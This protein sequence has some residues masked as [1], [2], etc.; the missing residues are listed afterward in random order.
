VLIS[1]LVPMLAA[2]LVST[3]T[4]VPAYA[5]ASDTVRRIVIEARQFEYSPSVIRVNRGEKIELVLRSMDVTHGLSLEE[6]GI[7]LE[8]VPG[9]EAH[10][11]FYAD[12]QG[13]F[14]FR[15]NQVCGNLHPFMTGGLIVEPNRPFWMVFALAVLGSVAFGAYARVRRGPGLVEA[16]GGNVNRLSLSGGI[17]IPT[18]SSGSR[19]IRFDV[20]GIRWIRWLLNRR[21]FQFVLLLP[22]LMVLVLILVAGFAGSPVG[23]HNLAIVLVWSIWWALLVLVLIPIGGRAWCVACPIPAP[24]EWLQR[25]ALVRKKEGKPFTIGLSWPRWLRN[26]WPQN[27]AFLCVAALSTIVLT[28]PAMTAWV[29]VAFVGT[30]TAMA[31]LFRGRIF[32]RYICPLS[33]FIGLYTLAAPLSLRVRSKEVCRAHREKSC[34]TG[35]ECGYGCPWGEY[36]GT[37]DRGVDCGLCME[38]VKT[39]SE[40]NIAVGFQAPGHDLVRTKA[41]KDEAFRAAI[42]ISVAFVYTV[43]MLG[44]WGWFKTAAGNPVSVP[45]LLYLV[46]LAGTSL[47]VV[48]GALLGV[49]YLFRKLS[50]VTHVST[51]R[52][53]AN[54][55]YSL[56]PLGLLVWMIFAATA[57]SAGGSHL[58]TV[59]S[60]PLGRGWDLFGTAHVK[61]PPLFPQLLPY[62]QGTGL[63]VGLIGSLAVF[64]H[65]MG[66]DILRWNPRLWLG[67]GAV[68]VTLFGITSLFIWLMMG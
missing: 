38:C 51:T 21:S 11:E 29:L 64:R 9:E 4:A 53:W 50:G 22:A 15:C 12:R 36:P 3:G 55:C 6:Y 58:P 62:L 46:F 37:M 23:D 63:L 20:T 44:P 2:L 16:T 7:F 13:K 31:L 8:A 40:D 57:L 32:C 17:P 59:L 65:R 18:K 19:K 49:A 10:A 33:G 27:I 56:V 52:V 54:V 42:A 61:W 47:L 68:A 5:S 1:L 25:L 60:D 24:G 43:V 35:N 28:T 39:C 48:P 14:S 41:Q 26:M 45:F 66:G 30:A 34:V 67:F